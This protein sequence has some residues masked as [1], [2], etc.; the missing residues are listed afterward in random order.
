MTMRLKLAKRHILTVFYLF[1]FFP[2][3]LTPQ[4]SPF[5]PTELPQLRQE[6]MKGALPALQE[7][8]DKLLVEQV[9]QFGFSS[10]EEIK[11][12][13]CG[14]AIPIYTPSRTRSALSSKSAVE[15]VLE[16]RPI[17][18]FVP[19]VEKGY[20]KA[21]LK[22]DYISGAN[23]RVVGFGM[24]FA[25]NRIDAGIHS[26]RRSSG[27]GNDL[28]LLSFVEPATDILLSRLSSGEWL[29]VKLSGTTAAEATLMDKAAIGILLRDLRGTAT[30][31]F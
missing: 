24:T 8:A 18:W 30:A 21:L 3:M 13:S 20:T 17:S 16:E 14:T 19:I 10:K 6:V 5:K 11:G 12:A 27:A 25:A 7:W 22:V 29:W 23:P 26:L 4:A 1:L 15:K 2:I 9:S 31:P 28:R